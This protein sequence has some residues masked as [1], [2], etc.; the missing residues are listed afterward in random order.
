MLVL[1]SAALAQSQPYPPDNYEHLLFD[2]IEERHVFSLDGAPWVCRSDTFCKPIKIDGVADKDLKQ[3]TI[4][5]LGYA[6]RRY[7]LSYGHANLNKGRPI[8]LSC[9]DTRCEKLDTTIGATASLGV[10]QVKDGD[11]TLTRTALLRQV[12]ERKGRAQLLWCSDSDCSEMPLTRDS[13]KYLAYMGTGFKD[14]QSIAWLRDRSGDVISCAQAE[15]GISDQL[16]CTESPTRLSDFPTPQQAAAPAPAP[17]PVAAPVPS[18]ADRNALASAID[19]AIVAGDFAYA[20]RLLADANRRF[21]RDGAWPPLQQKLARMRAER[22]AQLR[23]AEAERLIDEA[24]RFARVGEFA[25]A[26]AMLQDAD[27][28][29]PGFADIARARR[30][31]AEL[32]TEQRQRYRERYQYQAAIDEAFANERLWEAERLLAEYAQRFNQDDEYRDRSRRLTQMRAAAAWQT[33]LTQARGFIANA[34]QAMTRGDFAEAERQLER[35]DRAA[36]GFPETNQARAELS[37]QRIAAE[38][39]QAEMRQLIAAIEASFQRRQY[40]DAER[41]IADGRRRYANYPVWDE[42]QSRSAAARRGDG[43]QESERRTRYENALE[44]VTAARRSTTQGDFAAAE[45]SLNEASTLVPKMPEIATASA[46]LERA[47]ADRA[48]QMAE[49]K[50]MQASI[51]AALQRK[52]YADAERLLADGSK[53]Y[54]SDAGWAPRT[55]RLAEERRATPGQTGNAPMPAPAPKPGQQPAPDRPVAA[56]PPAATPATPA[57]PPVATVKPDA[58]KAVAE[59]KAAIARSQFAAAEK[60][61]SEAEQIDAKAASV[62]A[63]RKELN[64]ARLV[65]TAR[66]NIRRQN[67]EAAE[68]AVVEAEKIDA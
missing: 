40:D 6:G 31:I 39:R 68:K 18:N 17:A 11:R 61:V 46:E 53:R 48:R 57:T 65:A 4:E 27:K 28:Q 63:V 5:P 52:Q 2:P 22:D 38:R 24:W 14:G 3:A 8:T 54:P 64:L 56:A 20:E 41:A 12:D 13:E 59:A 60:A 67:F 16:T 34:R 45:R 15:A 26:E 47:K 35:A 1:S 33:R 21:A 23:R 66:A 42:L 44:L 37:R 62:V 43:R 30:E 51:D 29:A 10:F 50:A 49:I 7:F 9:E 25:N 19:Q 58:S 36:P 32:R 55:A